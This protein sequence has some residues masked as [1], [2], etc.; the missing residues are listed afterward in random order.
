M[1]LYQSQVVAFARYAAA[2]VTYHR[3]VLALH[4]IDGTG[5]CR[6]CGRIWPCDHVR[7]S[8]QMAEHFSQWA[9]TEEHQTDPELVRRYISL[10]TDS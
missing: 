8:R 2:Q 7:H 9:L 3:Q 1:G 10:G 6:Q 4:E 5:C